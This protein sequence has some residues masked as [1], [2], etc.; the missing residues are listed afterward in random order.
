MT[1]YIHVYVIIMPNVLKNKFTYTTNID[2][3]VHTSAIRLKVGHFWGHVRFLLGV[4]NNRK[5]K[6]AL[7]F[8][9]KSL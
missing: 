9:Y 3:I 8:F 2:I 4:Q 5:L 6:T 1:Q 7:P